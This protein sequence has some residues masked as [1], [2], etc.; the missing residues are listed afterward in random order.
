[1]VVETGLDSLYSLEDEKEVLV[2]FLDERGPQTTAN[3]Q[4]YGRSAKASIIKDTTRYKANTFGFYAP[5]GASVISFMEN[6]KKES[7][8]SFLE[9]IRECTTRMRAFLWF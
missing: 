7:V 3:T 5:N 2:G 9:E 8:C 6:S 4:G 1:M